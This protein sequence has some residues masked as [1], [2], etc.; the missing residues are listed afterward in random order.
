MRDNKREGHKAE[1]EEKGSGSLKCRKE[2]EGETQKDA[3]S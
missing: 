3:R 1:K 2:G